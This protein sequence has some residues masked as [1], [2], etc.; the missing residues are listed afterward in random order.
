LSYEEKIIS[1]FLTCV[2][3]SF[4]CND[5]EEGRKLLMLASKIEK[6]IHNSFVEIVEKYRK[7]EGYRI[8]KALCI[9]SIAEISKFVKKEST[10]KILDAFKY[11]FIVLEREGVLKVY[12]E[13]E[14]KESYGREVV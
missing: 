5:K 11:F 10:K 2:G 12:R 8:F 6:D 14:E 4:I 7:E 9:G 3:L 1:R 13:D